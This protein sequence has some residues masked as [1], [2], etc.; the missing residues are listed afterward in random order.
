MHSR[1]NF[2]TFTWSWIWN[3][4]RGTNSNKRIQKHIEIGN[5]HDFSQLSI[6]N[7]MENST[8]VFFLI[9]I[10]PDYHK[11]HIIF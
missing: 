3:I 6:T 7:S 1:L 5:R 8:V 11:A 10:H 9:H 2:A 4:D